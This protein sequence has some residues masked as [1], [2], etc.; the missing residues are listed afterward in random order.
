MRT[1]LGIAAL[2][3]FGFAIAIF[4]YNVWRADSQPIT[5]R[6]PVHSSPERQAPVFT[7]PIVLTETPPAIANFCGK[8]HELPPPDCEPRFVWDSKIRNMYEIAQRDLKWPEGTLP[9]V[10][11]VI[12]FYQNHAPVELLLDHGARVDGKMSDGST[13][14]VEAVSGGHTNVVRLLLEK[15]ADPSAKGAGQK[16]L[17]DMAREQGNDAVTELLDARRSR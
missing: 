1:K 4:S 16:T 7:P 9:P 8:C 12:E 2:L 3:F 5:E 6:T 10:G 15:G 17:I 14:L 13:P 11:D